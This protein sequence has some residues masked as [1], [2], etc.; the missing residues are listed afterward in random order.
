MDT[1]ARKFKGKAKC[2]E[3]LLEFIFHPIS[4]VFYIESHGRNFFTTEWQE[5]LRF[6]CGHV[7][8]PPKE[9]KVHNCIYPPAPWPFFQI[10]CP[11]VQHGR[12]QSTTAT[13]HCPYSFLPTYLVQCSLS[14]MFLICICYK[15]RHVLGSKARKKEKIF[16]TIQDTSSQKTG[17]RGID[18]LIQV[19]LGLSQLKTKASML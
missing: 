5:K 6:P 16:L 12:A 1:Q 7:L 13:V 17:F 8:L 9:P 15:L 18:H 14:F 10:G 3:K 4:D 19:H 2:L 11:K